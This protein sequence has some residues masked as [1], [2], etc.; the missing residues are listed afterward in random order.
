MESWTKEQLEPFVGSNVMFRFWNTHN[1]DEAH[2]Q[3]EAIEDRFYGFYLGG[4]NRCSPADNSWLFHAM[5]EGIEVEGYINN[6]FPDTTKGRITSITKRMVSI[7][8]ETDT[9][10]EI[11]ID[12]VRPVTKPTLKPCYWCG[13]IPKSKKVH[14]AEMPNDENMHVIICH[15]CRA[16]G[17]E[18]M[19]AQ[20]A[21]QAWNRRT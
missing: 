15:S 4:Y 14:Y 3:L 9:Y 11:N 18:L 19:T 20:E 12:S 7:T 1:Q 8:T 21:I 2:G 13:G 6:S 17:P 5:I 16:S 10:Q